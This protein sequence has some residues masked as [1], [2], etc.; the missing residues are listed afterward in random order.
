MN[1]ADKWRAIIA[2]KKQGGEITYNGDKVYVGG[3][4][5]Y[6]PD[7]VEDQELFTDD[8]ET[9]LWAYASALDELAEENPCYHSNYNLWQHWNKR[10]RLWWIG[11]I[12][13]Q[14]QDG[15]QTIGVDVVLRAV[16]IRLSR[17]RE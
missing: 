8:E 10:M 16:E 17:S 6:S 15:K 1:L 3:R 12:E 7:A 9:R 11:V 5:V 4:C 13:K 2:A 14:A